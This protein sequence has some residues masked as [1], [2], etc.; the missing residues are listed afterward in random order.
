MKDVV[1]IAIDAP[2]ADVARLF[3]DPTQSMRWMKDTRYEPISGEQ[4]APGSRYRLVMSNAGMEF[5]ATV[6]ARDL[7]NESRILLEASSVTVNIRATLT[8]LAARKTLLVSEELF[9]FNGFAGKIMSV[10]ARRAIRK[11]HLEQ[12][13]SFKRFVENQVT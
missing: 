3:A 12:M 13:Q 8:A 7:P 10:L 9:T 11:A 1:R 4:G 2:V 6:V 5:T